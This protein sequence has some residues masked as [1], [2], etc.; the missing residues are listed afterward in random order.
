[1]RFYSHYLPQSLV[2][3]GVKT[4]WTTLK[5]EIKMNRI[6]INVNIINHFKIFLLV[7]ST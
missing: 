6:S 4:E 1:M 2:F 3:I 7:M 5:I